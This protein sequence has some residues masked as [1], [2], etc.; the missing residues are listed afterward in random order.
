MTRRRKIAIA[1]CSIVV[2]GIWFLVTDGLPSIERYVT[3]QLSL[4]SEIHPIWREID[5]GQIYAGQSVDEI[6]ELHQPTETETYGPYT[7]LGFERDPQP[8]TLSFSGLNIVAKNG[9]VVSAS[10][11]SCT[12]QRTFFDSM[13]PEDHQHLSELLTESL[14]SRSRK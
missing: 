1:V 2:L 7:V 5:N 10:A 11:G 14:A 4:R 13:S 3:M 9:K 6:F 8:N 12:W